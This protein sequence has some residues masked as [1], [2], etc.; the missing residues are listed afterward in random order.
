[1]TDVTEINE[2]EPARRLHARARLRPGA[3][4]LA[5]LPL[6]VCSLVAPLSP[7]PPWALM[8]ALAITLWVAFKFLAWLQAAENRPRAWRLAA[9]FLWPGMDARAFSSPSIQ[10]PRR[11][12]FSPWRSALL[13]AFAGLILLGTAAQGAGHPLAAGWL[14]IT[15]LILTLHFGSFDLLAAAWNRAGI[16][17]RPLMDAPWRSRNL[18]EFWGRRWNRGFSDVARFAVFQ[19]LARRLGP[20][21]G[22]MAGFAFSG[23]LHEL[24]LSLPARGGFGGPLLYFLIQGAAV[25]ALRHRGAA[26][27]PVLDRFLTGVIV[28]APAFLLFHPP[29]LERVLL[30]FLRV[31]IPLGTPI[32]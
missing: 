12:D 19:P 8:W 20:A 9:Y 3:A 6:A 30:P 22:T 15:G 5:T 16:P 11:H 7:M 14:A 2:T 17:V 28:L 24:V 29:F 23:L 10:T 25:C 21:T 32:S 13:R 4:L 27:P 1:M 26:L 31:L 18:A